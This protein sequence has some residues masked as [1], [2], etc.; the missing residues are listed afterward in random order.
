MHLFLIVTP[1]NPFT[2]FDFLCHGD[3]VMEEA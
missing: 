1:S 2:A 3:S